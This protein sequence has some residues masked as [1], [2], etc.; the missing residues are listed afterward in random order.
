[1]QQPKQDNAANTSSD[2]T[3]AWWKNSKYICPITHE[4]F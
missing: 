4:V 3:T 2:K 1:M